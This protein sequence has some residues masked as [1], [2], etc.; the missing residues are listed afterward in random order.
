MEGHGTPHGDKACP[1]RSRRARMITE[2]ED[3]ARGIRF[4]EWWV[5]YQDIENQFH[6]RHLAPLAFL[7]LLLSPETKKGDMEEMRWW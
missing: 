4:M 1:C 7:L 6:Q 3:D 2:K 5:W